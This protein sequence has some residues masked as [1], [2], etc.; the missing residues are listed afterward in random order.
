MIS[1]LFAVV[2][3]SESPHVT[4]MWRLSVCRVFSEYYY[5]LCVV[6]VLLCRVLWLWYCIDTCC[7]VLYFTVLSNWPPRPPA[8]NPPVLFFP[9]Q[10]LCFPT[11]ENTVLTR[12]SAV[13]SVKLRSL[14]LSVVWQRFSHRL[15]C[16]IHQQ[17]KHT[18]IQTHPD[19]GRFRRRNQEEKRQKCH[20]TSLGFLLSTTQT[21]QPKKLRV[22]VERPQCLTSV[23][24]CLF[25]NNRWLISDRC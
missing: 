19:Q 7:S 23:L 25:I 4:T 16:D 15:E 18:Q 12:S 6:I 1:V 17:C 21:R 14:F 5:L 2:Q 20:L 8:L 22:S 24:V 9:Q 13:S 11:T 3:K 10:I